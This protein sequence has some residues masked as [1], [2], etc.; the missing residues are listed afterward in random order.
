M[1][2]LLF[3]S[4]GASQKNGNTRTIACA[5]VF[6]I[7]ILACFLSQFKISSTRTGSVQTVGNVSVYSLGKAY[8]FPEKTRIGIIIAGILLCIY[9]V[10][11]LIIV[12]RSKNKQKTFFRIYENHIEGSLYDGLAQ[13]EF[14]LDYKQITDVQLVHSLGASILSI[15]T[16]NGKYAVTLDKD[17]N[18]A[19]Q[20]INEKRK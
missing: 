18:T 10:I 9:A 8:L 20:L 3:E 19:Y 1:E 17:G 11:M 13:R 15:K 4:T 14:N 2:K 5:V 12:Q 16:N 7:G 6:I